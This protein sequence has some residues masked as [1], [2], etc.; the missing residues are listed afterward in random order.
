MKTTFELT[1]KHFIVE[2]C[3]DQAIQS[4]FFILTIN[5]D[6]EAFDLKRLFDRYTRYGVKVTSITLIEALSMQ[7]GIPVKN[8][9]KAAIKY[10][11]KV[12]L[13]TIKHRN[14]YEDRKMI[15]DV[16]EFNLSSCFRICD[17]GISHKYVDD[18]ITFFYV[19][20]DSEFDD[21]IFD[22]KEFKKLLGL[23]VAST[24]AYYKRGTWKFFRSKSNPTSWKMMRIEIVPVLVRREEYTTEL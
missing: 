17:V 13:Y 4:K 20:C 1:M 12:K 7:S 15:T 14:V 22:D 19:K 5:E 6:I 16:I 3:A 21:V 24:D 9:L 11:K 18:G 23:S 8:G 10:V 2:L